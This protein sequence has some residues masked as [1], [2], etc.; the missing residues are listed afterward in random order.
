[1]LMYYNKDEHEESLKEFLELIQPE[2]QH[3][4]K[5]VLKTQDF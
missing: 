4:N 5:K 2:I 3:K 1:M